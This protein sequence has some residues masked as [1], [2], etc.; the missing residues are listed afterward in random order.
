M[1]QKARDD[2]EL[3]VSAISFWEISLLAAKG[4]LELSRPPAELRAELLNTS[5]F[6]IPLTGE[7]AIKAVSLETLH[8]DPA[9]RFIVATA[10][11][12]GATLVTADRALLRWKSRL[13]RQNAAK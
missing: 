2:G 3:A 10:I 6:E 13:A 8:G 11:I 5:V 9:D 1:I 12:H 7:I 4:R